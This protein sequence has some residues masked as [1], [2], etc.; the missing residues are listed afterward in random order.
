MR[1]ID[2][3]IP[4]MHSVYSVNM[5][6]GSVISV[7]ANGVKKS[8]PTIVKQVQMGANSVESSVRSLFKQQPRQCLLFHLV[9]IPSLISVRLITRCRRRHRV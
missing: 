1:E 8:V 4:G 6:R 7:A 9:Y 2:S 3:G 5:K